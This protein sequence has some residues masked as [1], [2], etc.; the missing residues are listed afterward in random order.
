[1][2]STVQGS[3]KAAATSGTKW[4]SPLLW[5]AARFS[6]AGD[7]EGNNFDNHQQGE[8]VMG[9]MDNMESTMSGKSIDPAALENIREHEVQTNQQEEAFHRTS[10]VDQ[11]T[12]T[13]EQEDQGDFESGYKEGQHMTSNDAGSSKNLNPTAQGITDKAYISGWKA[14]FSSKRLVLKTLGYDESTV[15][16]KDVKRDGHGVE[17]MEFDFDDEVGKGRHSAGE[18]SGNGKSSQDRNENLEQL[19]TRRAGTQVVDGSNPMKSNPSDK[20]HLLPS[21]QSPQIRNQPTTSENVKQKPIAAGCIT[22]KNNVDAKEIQLRSMSCHEVEFGSI[23]PACTPTI[24]RSY[25]P[26][27]KTT[28]PGSKPPTVPQSTA[29]MAQVAISNK[30]SA[31]PST[32]KDKEKSL[33]STNIVLPSWEDTFYAPPRNILPPNPP[34]NLS[35]R[36]QGVAG[37]RLLERAMG[38]VSDVLFSTSPVDNHDGSTDDNQN[39]QERVPPRVMKERFQH[40][41]KELPHAWDI[42]EPSASNSKD[43]SGVKVPLSSP[44]KTSIPDQSTLSRRIPWRFM[45]AM[46]RDKVPIQDNHEAT[47]HHAEEKINDVLRGSRRVV[48]IGIHGWFPG[49]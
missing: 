24:D 3:S 43:P 15:S 6:P 47:S 7:N 9:L 33:L 11:T 2:K 35:R 17:V 28:D 40:F 19:K 10:Q 12:V 30:C 4:F 44:S 46:G 13:W 18:N 45:A 8:L 31:S 42:L 22:S 37:G 26:T 1:M 27:G 29:P 41:G 5:Y 21:S 49:E 32:K 14:L 23:T 38:F 20:K 34:S 48:V 25:T 16:D 39:I 36:N